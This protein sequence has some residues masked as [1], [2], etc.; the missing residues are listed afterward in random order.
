MCIEREKTHTKNFV[1]LYKQV[2]NDSNLSLK[3]KGLWAYLMSL[4]D[5]WKIS[6]TEVAKHSTDGRDSVRAGLQELVEQGYA[7]KIKT[8]NDQGKFEPGG[9]II[10]ESKKI[11]EE[12]EIQ[13]LKNKVPQTAFPA[14]VLPT[15]VYPALLNNEAKPSNE[16]TKKERT[17]KER[18]SDAAHRLASLFFD[19]LLKLNPDRKKPNLE[20]WADE[21]EKM[22][23]IDKRTEQQILAALNWCRNDA[24]YRTKLLIPKKF[25]EGFDNLITLMRNPYNTKTS[26]TTHNVDFKKE[27]GKDSTHPLYKDF[28]KAYQ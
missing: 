25:R 3:A 16:K 21:F 4:P 28:T 27:Q 7:K 23:I 8:T 20:K 6:S 1:I 19:S 13:E 5:D 11:N 2:L 22:L 15:L 18:A 26:N 9:W 17:K 12:H 14:M 24:F 10:Y